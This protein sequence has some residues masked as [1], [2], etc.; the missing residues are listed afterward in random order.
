MG[1]DFSWNREFWVLYLHVLITIMTFLK[2]HLEHYGQESTVLNKGTAV[3]LEYLQSSKACT[4]SITNIIDLK[5]FK[6]AFFPLFILP[7]KAL[8]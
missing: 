3:L 8:F 5:S 2:M 7:K 1:L 4:Y 6:K